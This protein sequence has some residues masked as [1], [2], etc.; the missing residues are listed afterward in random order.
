M[1]EYEE[2]LLQIHSRRAADIEAAML[3]MRMGVDVLA[4]A[5]SDQE[6]HQQSNHYGQEK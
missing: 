5:A 1:T 4:T 6:K 3:D 2:M